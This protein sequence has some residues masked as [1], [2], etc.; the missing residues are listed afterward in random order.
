[1]GIDHI[2][3]SICKC[4]FIKTIINLSELITKIKKIKKN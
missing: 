2:Y 3:V 1:M 4:N